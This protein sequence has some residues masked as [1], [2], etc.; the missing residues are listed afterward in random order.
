MCGGRCS[1]RRVPTADLLRRLAGRREGCGGL[2]DGPREGEGFGCHEM[3]GAGGVRVPADPVGVGEAV[4]DPARLVAPVEPREQLQCLVVCLDRL[5][6]AARVLEG[7]AEVV[8]RPGLPHAVAHGLEQVPGPGV[9]ADDLLRAARL[10]QGGAQVVH[11]VAS[12]LTSPVCSNSSRAWTWASA[13]S[14]N[15]PVARSARPRLFHVIASLPRL[16]TAR[17]RSRARV[18]ASIAS[19]PR[20]TSRRAAPVLVHAQASPTRSPNRRA[21]VRALRHTAIRSS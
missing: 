3:R 9:G 4:Q 2:L 20:P 6:S 7:D 14:P 1:D 8:P 17:N 15:A 11:A 18:W 12:P 21:A 5:R 16:P 19:A 10:Q 13:A